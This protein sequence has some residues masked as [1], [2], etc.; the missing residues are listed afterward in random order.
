MLKAIPEKP[1]KQG[2]D[3]IR[4]NFV[5]VEERASCRPTG[6]FSAF[7]WSH[8]HKG[9]HVSKIKCPN[10][11]KIRGNS[12]ETAEAANYIRW[13]HVIFGAFSRFCRACVRVIPRWHVHDETKCSTYFASFFF[14]FSHGKMASLTVQDVELRAPKM[15]YKKSYCAFA[16]I[17]W[18]KRFPLSAAFV[19]W[20]VCFS[21]L[22]KWNLEFFLL[23]WVLIFAALWSETG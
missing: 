13:C 15:I 6:R 19:R 23:S 21:I 1:C 4:N 18:Y 9:F 22:A 20:I 3:S 5:L 16:G 14:F 10:N 17:L 7:T 11:D 2:K 8:C 12:Y